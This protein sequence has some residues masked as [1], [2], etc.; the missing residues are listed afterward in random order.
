[1]NKKTFIQNAV[2]EFLPKTDWNPEKAI[3]YA[4]RLWS[5]LQKTYHIES[6]AG[7]RASI[8]Y[9]QKLSNHQKRLFDGF[10]MRFAYKS[11]KQGAARRWAELGDIDDDI[12]KK[13]LNAAKK[14]A[15]NRGAMK[16][17]PPMAALWLAERRWEDMDTDTPSISED[18][19]ANELA[20]LRA[21]LA[22]ARNMISIDSTGVWEDQIKKIE[23][24]IAEFT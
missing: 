13:I 22:H 6:G 19:A 2:I 15:D 16:T 8:N 10:W 21:D 7:P 17:T 18:P 14:E 23:S 5:V 12:Y 11:G 9:Y 4:E 24:R 1:M 20:I 3:A